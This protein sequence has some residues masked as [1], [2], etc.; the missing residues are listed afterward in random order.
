MIFSGPTERAVLLCALGALGVL[1]GVLTYQFFEGHTLEG[2]IYFEGPE[3][4]EIILRESRITLIWLGNFDHT[5][6]EADERLEIS[7]KY[8]RYLVEER[9]AT[10]NQWRELIALMREKDRPGAGA[11]YRSES[12]EER[13]EDIVESRNMLRQ[14]VDEA[15][16]NFTPYPFVFPF[17]VAA[18]TRSDRDGR[19]L[20][21]NLPS[22]HYSV[23]C[24]EDVNGVQVLWC[25]RVTLSWNRVLDLTRKNAT[26]VF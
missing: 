15:S 21:R 18:Q 13:L 19:Y 9:L 12:V 5:E 8:Y 26:F 14:K 7:L 25:F 3:R 16:R 10:Q 1:L 20:F 23:L 17:T 2:E 11:E 22:G 6:A 24:L 4:Q